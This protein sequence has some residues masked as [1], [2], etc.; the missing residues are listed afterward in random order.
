MDST[1]ARTV[2][3]RATVPW[4][5]ADAATTAWLA[6]GFSWAELGMHSAPSNAET[7]KTEDLF[8]GGFRLGLRM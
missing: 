6:P 3:M 4:P 8:I 7:M 5:G 1:V 2:V